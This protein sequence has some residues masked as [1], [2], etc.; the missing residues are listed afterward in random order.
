MNEEVL[1]RRGWNSHLKRIFG[2]FGREIRQK[3]E[4]L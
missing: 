2:I 3:V 4:I 1:W